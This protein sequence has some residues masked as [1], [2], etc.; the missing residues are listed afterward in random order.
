MESLRGRDDLVG[1]VQRCTRISHHPWKQ[2]WRPSA[3]KWRRVESNSETGEGHPDRELAF[4][5][6]QEP[7]TEVANADHLPGATTS[8]SQR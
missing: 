1:K 7:L 6:F 4:D 2:T 3:M 8:G 5:C